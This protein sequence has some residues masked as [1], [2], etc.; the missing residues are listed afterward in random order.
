MARPRR[1]FLLPDSRAGELRALQADGYVRFGAEWGLGALLADGV[2]RDAVQAALT[3]S[4]LESG[5]APGAGK[6]SGVASAALPCSGAV[7]VLE[8]AV[9]PR[10]LALALSYL[11]GDAELLPGFSAIRLP[12][13]ELDTHAYPA[14][15]WHRRLIT[16]GLQHRINPQPAVPWYSRRACH[17]DPPPP[18][19]DRCGHRLKLFVLLHDVGAAAHPTRIAVGSHETLWYA[20]DHVASSRFADS[21][22]RAGYQLDEMTGL[23]HSGYIFDTNA[24]HQ[25]ANGGSAG[26]DVLVFEVNPREKSKLL[27]MAP[28]GYARKPG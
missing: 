27:T 16:A 18:A 2:L 20:H 4:A 14:A 8:E 1:P 25:A 24:L 9:R 5:A 28:C 6:P 21:Y 15:Y 19:D 23:M 10:L 13:R 17:S 26:R 3:A 7:R 22:V 12:P 11:G